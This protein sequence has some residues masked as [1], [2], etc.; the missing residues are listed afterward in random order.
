MV[1]LSRLASRSTIEW[2]LAPARAWTA[3]PFA[4]PRL[5][6]YSATGC[7][8]TKEI[9]ATVRMIDQ[10]VHHIMGAVDDVEDAFWNTRF[11]RQLGQAVGGEG[12][13]LRR[14]QNEGVAEEI[15]IGNIQHGTIM[16]KLNGVILPIT[17][18][19]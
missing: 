4:V 9:R 8:P 2:F 12:G 5:Y 11:L 15:A 1:A 17:P 7:E 16:G 19:G 6:T 14:L 13:A 10:S 3:F 18:T